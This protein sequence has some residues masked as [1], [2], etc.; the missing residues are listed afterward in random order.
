MNALTNKTSSQAFFLRVLKVIIQLREAALNAIKKSRQA[1]N[2]KEVAAAVQEEQLER[3]QQ[4]QQQPTETET[5]AA[6]AATVETEVAPAEGE[7][8]SA[9]PTPVSETTATPMDVEETV[10][11]SSA[12]KEIVEC[13]DS[14][15]DELDLQ[16]LWDALSSCLRDL[17][18]TPDHHAVLVLQV[19]SFLS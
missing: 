11:E 5:A 15:S 18:H 1:K 13:L 3:Q 4:Q 8:A 12:A 10:A 9:T 2:A 14:L 16:P 19:T 7:A 17:A 6:A